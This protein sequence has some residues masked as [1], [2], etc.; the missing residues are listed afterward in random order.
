VKNRSLA[1]KLIFMILTCTSFILGGIL[2]YN[3]QVSRKMILKNIE[4]NARDLSRATSQKIETVLHSIKEVPET[5]AEVLEQI[6]YDEEIL[7]KLLYTAV[8][9]NDGIFGST[10]AFEPKAF[11]GVSQYYAPYWYRSGGELKLSWLGG[12]DYPYSLFDWYQIPKELGKLCWTEPYYDEGGGNIIMSTCSAPVY[13][14]FGEERRFMGV[15]TAD[16]SLAWLQQM[17]SSIKIAKTGYAFLVSKNGTFVTHPEKDLVMNETLFGLAEMRHDSALREIG[18]EMTQ[19]RSGFVPFAGL[20]GKQKSWM[21]YAPIPSTGWSVAVVFPQDELMSDVVRLSWAGILLACGGFILLLIVIVAISGTITKPLRRLAD[22]TKDIAKGNWDIDL[23]AP[24]SA[25]EV[26]ILTASFLSMKEALK[27]YIRDLTTATA[28]KE[29]MASELKIAHDIQMNFVPKTFPAFPNRKE[30]DIY[31]VLVPAQEVGGDLYDFFFLDE[32]RLCFVIGDVSGKGVPAAL[33]MAVTKML[34]KTSAKGASGPEEILKKVNLEIAQDNDSCIFV[35]VF[36]GIFNAKTGELSYANGGHNPPL[37]LRGGKTPEFLTGGRGPVL[38]VLNE[39]VFQTETVSFAPGDILY[40]YTDG[41]TEACD[42]QEE[43]YSAERLQKFLGEIPRTPLK[44]VVDRTLHEIRSFS[45]KMPQSDDITLLVLKY[46]GNAET[47]KKEEATTLVLKNNL[48]GL[49][50]LNVT[51][52]KLLERQVLGQRSFHD[53]GLV[54]EEV[55]VNIISHAY[56]DAREHEIFVDIEAK[57]E[58]VSLRVQD[59]GIPFNPLEF[60][61]PD[62]NAPLEERPVGGL[63][64]HMVRS[65]AKAVAYERKNECNILTMTLAR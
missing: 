5:L 36:C 21:A 22:A 18:R 16:V 61:P 14:K 34:L 12:N 10:I 54:L 35:T 56:S 15:I 48:A 44:G 57:G 31:A 25:D 49:S 1:L 28:A 62:L 43:L 39:A 29:R 3:Y 37:I 52:K 51:L 63:G 30:L 24:K 38:G 55:I 58:D 23:P 27:K 40:L 6:P 41:V 50:E 33:F 42:E 8:K 20:K 9:R 59:D 26:G 7:K 65:L 45:D 53:I 13:R 2:L 47:G 19:G 4:A 32:D 11:D 64:I 46:N 60:P 17:I